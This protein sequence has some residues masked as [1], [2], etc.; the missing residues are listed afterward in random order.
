MLS[1][2]KRE[3]YLIYSNK[4]FCQVKK[5]S[6]SIFLTKKN[7]RFIIRIHSDIQIFIWPYELNTHK[8]NRFYKKNKIK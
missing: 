6:A 1:R 8:C 3:S 2:K 4:N 5:T 7:E